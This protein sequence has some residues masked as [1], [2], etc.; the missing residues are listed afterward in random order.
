MSITIGPNGVPE[1]EGTLY[2]WLPQAGCP[3]PTPADCLFNWAE[4][5]YPTLFAPAGT[6][7]E[8]S[9]V[10]TYRYYSGTNAYLGV[11]SANND[12]YYIG[13]SGVWQNEGP[14]SNWLPLAG[15]Q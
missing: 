12:V 8:T 1:N 7:T 15:C 14:T 9:G 4:I 5:N 3:V 10:Y 11:S 2:D 13:P 6:A